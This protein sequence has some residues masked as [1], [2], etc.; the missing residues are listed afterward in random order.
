MDVMVSDIKGRTQTEG[1][2]EHGTEEN[3]G[4]KRD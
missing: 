4:P 1:V 2:W 3:I